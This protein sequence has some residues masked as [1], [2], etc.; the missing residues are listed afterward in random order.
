[1]LCWC[2]ELKQ[3]KFSRPHLSKIDLSKTH[4]SKPILKQDTL[5][6]DS[7]FILENAK[8]L[9]Y[10]ALFSLTVHFIIKLVHKLG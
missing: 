1:M 4:L 5:K 9:V 3:G 10:F 8:F 7:L 6:Q 2:R